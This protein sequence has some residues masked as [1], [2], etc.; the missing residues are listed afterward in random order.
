[1][2][3]LRAGARV[4]NAANV[5]PYCYRAAGMSAE[6]GAVQAVKEMGVSTLVDALVLLWEM[7]RDAACVAPEAALCIG[8]LNRTIE[9]N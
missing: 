9:G 1:M 7:R 4:I 8:E 6:E 2:K 5:P 3:N